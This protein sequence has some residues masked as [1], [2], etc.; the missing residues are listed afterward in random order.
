MLE[1]DVKIEME[2]SGEKLLLEIKAKY[3]EI[4]QQDSE[5]AA[6]FLAHFL[7]IQ[8]KTLLKACGLFEDLITRAYADQIFDFVEDQKVDF[9]KEYLEPLTHF[10]QHMDSVRDDLTR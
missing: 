5:I 6:A 9:W 8:C 1:S 4:Y 3:E 10:A 2:Q 7:K